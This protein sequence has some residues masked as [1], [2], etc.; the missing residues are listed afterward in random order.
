MQLSTGHKMLVS[1][2]KTVISLCGF[3]KGSESA[4][5]GER[6]VRIAIILRL[7]TL[8]QSNKR[9]MLA[10]APHWVKIS[11]QSYCVLKNTR[12]TNEI[13]LALHFICN[14][15]Y[16]AT[17]FTSWAPFRAAGCGSAMNWQTRGRVRR[18]AAFPRRDRHSWW[19]NVKMIRGGGA[20][21][22][23]HVHRLPVTPKSTKQWLHPF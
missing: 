18:G 14:R 10:A 12:Q 16:R 17:T 15:T 3:R 7:L 1:V 2:L 11:V 9:Q 8:W 5:F 22:V 4:S 23:G 19:E 20:T 6:I 13:E 21:G